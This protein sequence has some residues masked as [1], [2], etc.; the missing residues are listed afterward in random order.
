MK[1]IYNSRLARAML[2]K[3]YSTCMLFG[4]ILTKRDAISRTTLTHETIHVLQFHE[5]QLLGAPVWS[6]LAGVLSP[7]YLLGIPFSFYLLY[8]GECLVSYIFHALKG[9]ALRRLND[10]AY[11]ASALEMEAR[12]FEDDPDYPSVRRWFTFRKFY[13]TL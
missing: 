2:G 9:T 11:A 1:V 10:A 4:M 13:G 8:F 6:F 3:K 5:T 7:W 12:S